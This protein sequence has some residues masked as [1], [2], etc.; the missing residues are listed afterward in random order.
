MNAIKFVAKD[1]SQFTAALRKNVNNYFKENNIS[2]KGD[3]TMVLKSIVM[4]S[5]Y[6]V[7]FILILMVSMPAFYIF[8]LSILCGIGMAGIGMSVMHDAAH[9]SSSKSKWINRLLSSTIYMIGGSVFTWN[10]QHN[11]K[12]H[13]FTNI[14]GYD[15]DIRTK[16]IIRLSNAAPLK[17]I[18]RFQY[19]YAFFFYTL[20][21]V[22]K[23][24]N[25]FHQLIDYNKTGITK[26]QNAKPKLELIKLISYKT[27]YLLL[28]LILPMVVS[29]FS[30]WAV[31]L[32]F[33]VMHLTAGGI[34]SIIFQ[35]AHIAEEV[36]QPLPNIDGSIE[37][38]WAIHELQT[39]A[40][41]AK[42][43]RLLGWY[44]GGLNFQIEHHLFPNICHVHYRKISPIVERTALEFG[45][46]YNMAPTFG[47]AI[48]SHT[49]MLKNL[50]KAK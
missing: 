26:Q 1:K 39:T 46:Q 30:W 21:T 37:N 12:H 11:V 6:V 3:W 33:F 42:D 9:G 18:H 13:T 16:A 15:E 34:M 4:V 31:I 36:E 49:R 27:G 14:D 23:L 19:I 25:D 10:I 5:L 45:L 24:V 20:M 47:R 17:K 35:M 8:P 40:N 41:F 29:S 7:P 2:S 22:A 48:A 43:N 32:G 44:I 28:F 38:E 50:G